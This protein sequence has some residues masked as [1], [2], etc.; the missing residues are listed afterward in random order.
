VG[1]AGCVAQALRHD[2]TQGKGRPTT[3]S[4]RACYGSASWR[5]NRS[6]RPLPAAGVLGL[7]PEAFRLIKQQFLF[8]VVRPVKDF[9][10]GLVGEHR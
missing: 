5:A 10:G 4:I 1:A 2:R 8:G 3:M 6:F 9:G 7:A